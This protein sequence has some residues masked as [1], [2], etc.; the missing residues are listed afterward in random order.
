V[1]EMNEC[2][3]MGIEVLPPSVNES[4]AHFTVIHPV[5][6]RGEGIPTESGLFHEV[7]DPL[8]G[9]EKEEKKSRIRFGLAAIKGLGEE[10][11]NQI[12]FERKRE[13]HFVSLQDFAK[14]VPAKVVNKKTLE[15]L[16]FSGAFD[17]FGDRRAIVDSLE[18][19]SR[20]ARE[21]Q[22]KQTAGQIGLFGGEG[23]SS[24]E[25]ALKNSVA[26]KDDILAWE[27][28][29][30]G[31]FVSDHPLKGLS[32]YFEKYGTLIGSLV[33]TED[34]G[35]KRTL[36]GI[37]SDVRRIVTRSGKNMA[38][39]QL[40]DTS[41]KIEIAIFP[42]IYDKIPK[43]ALEMDA[44][45]RVRG[46]VEERNGNLNFI[47]DEIKVGN[48]K[49]VGKAFSAEEPAS[50]KKKPETKAIDIRIPA[51]TSR[52]QVD[53]LKAILTS[54]KSENGTKVN[55]HIE[56]RIVLLPFEVVP[57]ENYQKELS[58]LLSS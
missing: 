50:A 41:G 31:L 21:V 25:F 56:G 6:S 23:E 33:E 49:D 58:A 45:L 30:L 12:I 54:W 42:Q 9:E 11:V 53:E 38:L 40:E 37:V 3:S 26:T 39:L 20:F 8:R 7:N 47:A 15:A 46:K 17:E 13:G 2:S 24:I 18:E 10:T 32:G 35:E 28:E 22:S 44:F 51:G 34:V 1:L 43:P 27:R 4:G 19:L 52:A 57:P 55:I 36:H 48:L 16:A 5:E 29:S 14:R